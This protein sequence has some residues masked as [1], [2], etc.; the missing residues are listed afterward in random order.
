MIKVRAVENVKS[1]AV[2][3]ERE[4]EIFPIQLLYQVL[5]YYDTK[6]TIL[7]LANSTKR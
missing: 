3:S 2:S 1:T 7:I 5:S 4:N 6:R